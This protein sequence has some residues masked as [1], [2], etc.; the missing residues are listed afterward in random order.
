MT[1][2]RIKIWVGPCGVKEYE[3]K[4]LD[5]GFTN[6]YSGTEHIYIYAEGSSGSAA[7]WN[8]QVD[9]ERKH[10]HCTLRFEPA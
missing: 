4:F 9:Y 3:Q 1:T 8:A 6:P 5:A 10:G 7:A 2:Y